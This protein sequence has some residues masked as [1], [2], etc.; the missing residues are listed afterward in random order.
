MIMKSGYRMLFISIVMMGLWTAVPRLSADIANP[1]VLFDQGHGQ[2]FVIEKTGDLHL[3]AL[4]T[5]FRKNGFEV[6][7]GR[8]AITSQ[9][10]SG[11]DGLVI[12][13]P[14]MPFTA[15]ECAAIKKFI[16]RGGRVAVMIHI[17]PTVSNLL[18]E[19]GIV[20]TTGPVNEVIN[21][22]G[23]GGKDFSITSLEEH[24]LTRGLSSFTVYGSWGL[25]P[26]RGN[27]KIIAKSSQK[28]WVDLN[29]D[30]KYGP[31]DAAQEFGIVVAGSIGKGEFAV[32]GDDAIFQNRFL[33]NGNLLLG[34][35]LVNWMRE[36]LSGRFSI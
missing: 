26:E 27:A 15:S 12:S 23:G 30:G 16:E 33:K 28:S 17:T 1:V 8:Q 13:G 11:V 25:N 9:L 32:F 19:L 29:R 31:R 21:I 10:L 5:L 18:K 7:T 36:K 34:K 3:S 35:N 4:A 14:F 6:K 24:S 22:R 2:T 20:S